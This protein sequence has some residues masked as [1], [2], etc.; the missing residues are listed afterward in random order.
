MQ[1][2]ILAFGH[3]LKDSKGASANTQT[4]YLRDVKLFSY[5]LEANDRSDLTK[6]SH[7]DIR[8]YLQWMKEEGRSRATVTRTTAGLKSFYSYLCMQGKIER[9]PVHSVKTEKSESRPPQTLSGKEVAYLL[10]QPVCNGEMGIRDLAMLETLYATGIRVSEMTDLNRSDVLMDGK[11]IKCCKKD[12]DRIIP[13]HA[14]AEQALHNYMQTARPV[15]AQNDEE[16]ALF[17]NC[18]GQRMTRQGFWKIIKRYQEKAQLDK[19]ITPQ[20]IRHTFATH[21]LQNGAD[22]QSLQVLMG[23][24]DISSTQKYADLL[25]QKVDDVYR[26]AH[27]RAK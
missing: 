20:I 17:L 1:Q 2:M 8:E 15:M 11:Y 13:L 10:E 26:R 3:Y 23:H 22:L 6:V 5:Y 21:L 12:S 24:A 27:P 4:S 7:G 18:S 16:E 14:K 25:K 9:N 19:K